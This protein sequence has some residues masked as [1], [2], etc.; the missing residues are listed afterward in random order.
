MEEL[1][2]LR[3]YIERG[4]YADALSLVDEMED[5]SRDDKINRISSFLEVLLLHL[6]KQQAER[7]T[8]RSWEVSIRNAARAIRRTNKRHKAGGY[9]LTENDLGAA[10]DDAYLSALDSAAVEA[11]E[12]RYETEELAGMIDEAAIKAAALELTIDN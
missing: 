6:I 9:Y 4:R 10:I 7:R 1:V 8:T 11:F 5:M 12:G 2:Q 3:S